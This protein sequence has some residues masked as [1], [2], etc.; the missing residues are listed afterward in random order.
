M[1]LFETLINRAFEIKG[2]SRIEPLDLSK[3]IRYFE[4]GAKTLLGTDM[5]EKDV[6]IIT[7]RKLEKR[8]IDG[9]TLEE[10]KE[11]FNSR[12]FNLQCFLMHMKKKCLIDIGMTS[13]I[14]LDL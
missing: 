13:K 10:Q 4:V 1:S 7:V 6:P 9:D 11:F 14:S 12:F 3:I 2:F 8:T 5:I